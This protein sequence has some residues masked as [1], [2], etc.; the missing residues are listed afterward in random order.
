MPFR[1]AEFEFSFDDVINLFRKFSKVESRH[2]QSISN[3][4]GGDCF[5]VLN[6]DPKK[7]GNYSYKISK[8]IMT[9][10]L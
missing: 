2:V 1:S 4:R 5:W 9:N 6:T 3:P 7:K 8:F 10:L